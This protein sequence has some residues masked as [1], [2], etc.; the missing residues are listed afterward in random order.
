MATQTK[1]VAK[2]AAVEHLVEFVIFDGD[3]ADAILQGKSELQAWL[4]EGY[5]ID[6]HGSMTISYTARV[7]FLLVK[8]A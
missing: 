3:D 2:T 7:W 8:R 5:V 1:E 6:A 4:N